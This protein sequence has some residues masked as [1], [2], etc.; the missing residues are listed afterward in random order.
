MKSGRMRHRA[1]FQRQ[2]ERIDDYGNTAQE[3]GNVLTVWSNLKETTGKERVTSGSIENDRTATLRLRSNTQS[4]ALTEADRVVVRDAVWRVLGVANSDDKGAYL[5]MLLRVDPTAEAVSNLADLGAPEVVIEASEFVPFF[6]DLSDAGF[7][8]PLTGGVPTKLTPNP[9][10]LDSNHY[11]PY[12]GHQWIQQGRFIPFG[13]EAGGQYELRV[14]VSVRPTIADEVLRLSLNIGTDEEPLLIN[15]INTP[16]TA[17]AGEIEQV[18]VPF[19]PYIGGLFALNGAAFVAETALGST[20]TGFGL[21]IDVE[22]I[23]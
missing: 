6:V 12:D 17:S 5:D 22:R 3:W 11:A 16:L 14:T 4:R 21:K 1:V 9:T 20:I 13:T 10:L 23:S 2:V 7:T 15:A 18:T 8:A 19:D